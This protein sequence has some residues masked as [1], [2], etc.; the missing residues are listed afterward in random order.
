MWEYQRLLV[1]ECV[2]EVASECQS[3]FTSDGESSE[4][5][6]SYIR[7]GTRSRRRVP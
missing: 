7:W 5:K 4:N 1:N 2:C 3:E 6:L